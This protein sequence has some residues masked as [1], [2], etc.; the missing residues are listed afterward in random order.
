MPIHPRFPT[1]LLNSLSN[2]LF[3]IEEEGLKLP[4]VI[5]SAKTPLL[6]AEVL[7]LLEVDGLGQSLSI[8]YI[9]IFPLSFNV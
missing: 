4:F 9:Q 8:G 2:P 6:R 7:P 3:S 5:S 1:L